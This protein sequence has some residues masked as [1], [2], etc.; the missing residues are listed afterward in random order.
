MKSIRLKLW[1]SLMVFALFMIFVL[2]LFQIVFL[3]RFYTTMEKQQIQ[4]KSIEL[5][6]ILE[7]N[8]D[9]GAELDSTD[10]IDTFAYNYNLS[11]EVTNTVGQILYQTSKSEDQQMPNMFKKAIVQ[12]VQSTLTG[13]S[14]QSTLTHPRFGT[15]N[16]I[17]GLPIYQYQDDT[18]KT[19]RIVGSLIIIAPMSP[20][21]DTANILKQQL[22][23][24]SILLVFGASGIAF[25]ISRHLSKPIIQIQLAAKKIARGDLE[26]DLQSTS[27]DEIGQLAQ[28]ILEMSEELKKTDLLRK[29]LIGNISHEL[30][31]P[32]S[33]I[34]GYAE[35][36]RDIT[37]AIPEKR[38]KQLD[39]IIK[40]SDRLANLIKDI[41]NLSQLE[42]G[43]IKSDLKGIS[44]DELLMGV[45]NQFAML[46]EQ[47]KIALEVLTTSDLQVLGDKVQLEQ[48]FINLVS[49]AFHHSKENT[50]IAIRVTDLDSYVKI[51][52][53]D[54][55]C[56]IGKDY[57]ESIW[58]RYYRIK[59]A[60]EMASQGSG[61][62]LS[63]VKNILIK[64]HSEYGIQSEEGLGTTIWFTLKKI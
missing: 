42:T 43:A 16:L 50:L 36:L 24:I 32:L 30:R 4:K 63:I 58:D 61:L 40:E 11:I 33:L 9:L 19:N 41:L 28:A 57:L 15:E 22:F 34:K 6:D 55:G 21:A 39:I 37:G 23:Y 2:W 7:Q 25:Y 45:K 26:I 51:E 54:Q 5:V 29:E 60:E 44:L 18:A 31:T 1:S 59:N 14:S 52:V 3:E 8:T 10:V 49:N 20:V 12:I 46:A 48:V 53:V 13:E 35:T 47:K 64:H 56:G 17:L 38:E 62:G 27:K